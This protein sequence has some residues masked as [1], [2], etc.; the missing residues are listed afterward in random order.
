MI[1]GVRASR[2]LH[3][4]FEPREAPARDE[5]LS[6]YERSVHECAPDAPGTWTVRKLTGRARYDDPRRC[7]IAYTRRG[8]IL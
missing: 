2:T 6:E 3:R 4:G 7:A 1:Q 8:T 5:E